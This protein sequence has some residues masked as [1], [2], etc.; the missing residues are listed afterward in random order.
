M[1]PSLQSNSTDRACSD[2]HL[3]VT[4]SSSYTITHLHTNNAYRKRLR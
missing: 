3:D 1:Q 2:D 4:T